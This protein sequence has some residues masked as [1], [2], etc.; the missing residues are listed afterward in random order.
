MSITAQVGVM[1]PTNVVEVGN[2]ISSDQLAAIQNA[3]SPSA[4]NPLATINDVSE[5]S[6]NGGTVTNPIIINESA[7]SGWTTNF[8]GVGLTMAGGSMYVS[9]EEVLV[10]GF[11][12]Q[13]PVGGTITFGDSTTQTT[14]G[15]SD[16]PSDGTTYGRKDGAWEAVGGGGSDPKKAIANLAAGCFYYNGPYVFFNGGIATAVQVSSKFTGSSQYRLGYG[17]IGS[18]LTIFTLSMTTNSNGDTIASTG[19]GYIS[20][21][22]Q[23]VAYS[24]DYGTTWTYSD[25]TF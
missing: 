13:L 9:Q 19:I 5:S 1:I 24:D 16:A 20:V 3:A 4:A 18:S 15:I 14:A 2:E 25:Y 6:F 8:S 22:G 17:T 21:M 7:T 10:S 23:T 12:I 11:N